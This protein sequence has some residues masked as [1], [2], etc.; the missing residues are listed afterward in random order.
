MTA[1][2]KFLVLLAIFLSASSGDAF[3]NHAQLN[4]L[5]RFDASKSNP[6]NK[7]SCIPSYES[8]RNQMNDQTTK[9][10]LY[11]FSFENNLFTLNQRTLTVGGRITVQLVWRL[12][13]YFLNWAN[14]FQLNCNTVI[15]LTCEQCDQIWQFIGLWATFKYFW[16]HLICPNLSH[17]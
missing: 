2:S 13:T 1:L 6:T 8:T 16:Q 4:H 15:P 7:P 10:G 9:Q 14:P 11:L 12:I 17:S 5:F 3:V